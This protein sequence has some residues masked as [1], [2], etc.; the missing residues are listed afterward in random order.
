MHFNTEL[1]VLLDNVNRIRL[2]RLPGQSVFCFSCKNSFR[3]CYNLRSRDCRSGIYL[4]SHSELRHIQRVAHKMRRKLN[5]NHLP[6]KLGSD[7]TAKVRDSCLKSACFCFCFYFWA[8]VITLFPTGLI[9]FL[10]M[11]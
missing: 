5:T 6:H 2:S 9:Y 4:V 3:R 1:V 8:I 11:H 7:Y 10:K